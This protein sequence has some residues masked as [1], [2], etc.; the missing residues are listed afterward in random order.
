[1]EK[2]PT[3]TLNNGVEIPQ[4]G[5]GV[6]KVPSELIVKNVQ[7][8]LTLGYRQ[9][10]TA[11]FY[12]N[13]VGVGE[14]IRNA[15]IPREELFITTK[16][17]NDQHGYEQTKQAF[18]ES[19]GK[20]D[21]DYLDLYLIHWPMPDTFVDTWKALEEIY[22]AGKV[23][24][25]GVS[26]FLPHHLEKL[27]TVAEIKPVINQIEQHP[28]LSQEET[29]AYCQANHIAIQSWSPL[30]K[31]NYLDDPTL[32]EVAQKHA[33]SP[34]QIILRWHIQQDFIV[35]PK[36]LQEE[37]QIENIN[38]FD[39]SLTNEEMK[40]IHQLDEGYRLGTHPDEIHKKED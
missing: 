3:L 24:A 13:E 18:A 17:W 28:K 9:I 37:R 2:V 15:S 34:A 22:R 6:Y 25:I 33:K 35:I 4:V 20:L 5:L 11:S 8:A 36:S 29:V 38:I 31:A 30:G 23:R 7:T 21:L 27:L 16:V 10:D 40:A 19:L 1:M 39:F 14:A 26:N 32:L 12:E